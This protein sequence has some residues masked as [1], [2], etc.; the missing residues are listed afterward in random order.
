VRTFAAL[1]LAW[2]AWLAALWLQ[3]RAGLDW[4]GLVFPGA[5]LALALGVAARVLDP[6]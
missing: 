6:Q 5:V 1:A 3:E 4:L 2:P